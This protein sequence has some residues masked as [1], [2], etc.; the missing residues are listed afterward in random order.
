[1]MQVS[2]AEWSAQEKQIA[3]TALI[4]AQSREIDGLVQLIREKASKVDDISDVWRLNDFLSARRF[5]IDG[6]YDDSEGETLFVLAR[7]AKEG[8]VKTA[9]LQGLDA[10]KLAKIAALTRIL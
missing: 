3:Q 7:L 5:D 10:A 2:E 4:E 1:M 6:K 9:D 8:W